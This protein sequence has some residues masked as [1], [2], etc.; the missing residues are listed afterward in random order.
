MGVGALAP[1]GR[2]YRR[3]A[4]VLLMLIYVFNMVDRQVVNILAESIKRDLALHDWQIGMMSG[5]SFAVLYTVL[6]I[7]IARYAER[8]DRPLIIAAAVALWSGFT[9]LCGLAQSFV[10]LALI[11]VG[12]GIGESGCTPPALSLIADTAPKESRASA[13]AIYM[14]GAPIGSLLGVAFGGLVADAYGWR[15]AFMIVGLPGLL[16][17]AAAAATLREPR[18]GAPKASLA[19]AETAPS[20]RD[21]LRELAGKRAYWRM[22]AGVTLQAFISY[23][24][25]AFTASFFLRNY[26]AELAEA[27]ARFGLK[28]VGLLG[29]GLGLASG[30][31]AIVGT[32]LGGRLADRFVAR[33]PRAYAVIPAVGAI[34]ALPFSL[35]VLNAPSMT[36]A[37]ALL[38]APGLLS[39][40]WLG[41]SY[42]SVQGLVRPESRATATAILLFIANLIGLGL[43]PLAVGLVSDL[44]HARAGFTE[45]AAIKWSL[46][47]FA[48][49]ALPCA[50]AFW[51]AGKTMREDL[52]S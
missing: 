36:I 49:L 11:R 37:F 14:L 42:A 1:A 3:Y 34:A 15:A 4:L 2:G 30:G 50:W 7:P 24:A 51:S 17:A 41:P 21:T 32:L 45:A 39:A 5:L 9:A 35:A 33:D 26:S 8:G 38:L 16:L 27:S 52:V 29:L 22:V 44:L 6:G 25:L 40:M 31:T 13:I 23:G 47:G 10:Q 48:L 18:R 19:A 28:S 12:V 20:L 46:T 43:G